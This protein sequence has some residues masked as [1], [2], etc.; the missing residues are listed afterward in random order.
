MAFLNRLQN[1]LS[2]KSVTAKAISI[3]INVVGSQ[4][5]VYSRDKPKELFVWGVFSF[6]FFKLKTL[7]E[8]THKVSF[9]T[10]HI[11]I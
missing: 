7:E 1:C 9:E 4:I 6:F 10:F 2:G 5:A 3:G 11:G 8:S